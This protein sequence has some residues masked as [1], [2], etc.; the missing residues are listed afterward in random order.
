MVPQPTPTELGTASDNPS[1]FVFAPKFLAVLFLH[2]L[3]TRPLV[4]EKIHRKAAWFTEQS[5]E[6]AAYDQENTVFVFGL[7]ALKRIEQSCCYNSA[8][9]QPPRLLSDL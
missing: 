7:A 1:A 2:F 4:A 3:Q 9:L 8:M 5:R 6:T